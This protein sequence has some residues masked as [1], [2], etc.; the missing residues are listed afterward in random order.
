MDI[1]QARLQDQITEKRFSRKNIREKIALDINENLEGNFLEVFLKAKNLLLGWLNKPAMTKSG[2]PWAKR[3][4]LKDT[5]LLNQD[6]DVND[7][8]LETMIIVMPTDCPMT[9]QS[10]AGR[11]GNFLKL[12]S[13]FDNAQIAAEMLCVM[14]ESDMYDII[15]AEHSETGTILLRSNWS[16]SE[17]TMQFIA[18]TQYL[19]PMISKP[20]KVTKNYCRVRVSISESMILK[21]ENHHNEPLCLDNL[22][23]VNSIPMALD[24]F[25]LQF[26][27]EASSD[28]DTPEKVMNFNRL[29]SV[30]RDVYD[31]IMMNGN[32]FYI[33]WKYDK[34]GREYSQGYHAHI[35]AS[36]YKKSLMNFHKKEVIE[37]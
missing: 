9:I 22:N 20:R 19:P 6:L 12:G 15:L 2:K 18:S 24:E 25:M 27:E 8:V 5:V 34:R 10:V 37:L 36:E 14:C 32:K 23:M 33:P 31:Y 30:S 28:L 21:P 16:L 13:P 17:D 26:E 35:Q 1:I 7:I 4:L 29:K 3:Q 11:L